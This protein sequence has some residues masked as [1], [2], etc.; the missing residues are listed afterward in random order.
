MSSY[1][2]KI[3]LEELLARIKQMFRLERK[4]G[5]KEALSRTL[6]AGQKRT[7]REFGEER[8]IGSRTRY[9]EEAC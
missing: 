2:H 9:C 5:G 8:T 1:K 6:N 7:M 3:E 4:R